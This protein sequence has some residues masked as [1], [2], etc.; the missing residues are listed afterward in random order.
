[1]SKVGPDCSF[2]N[3]SHRQHYSHF[4]CGSYTLRRSWM[5]QYSHEL[6]AKRTSTS[7]HTTRAD[8]QAGPFAYSSQSPHWYILAMSYPIA[9]GSSYRSHW[10]ALVILSSRY[11]R[12]HQHPANT[13]QLKQ[14]ATTAANGHTTTSASEAPTC[15]NSSF[16]SAPLRCS[17]HQYT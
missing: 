14:E 9:H 1:M 11:Q 2:V 10:A 12:Q 17:Q 5:P 13:I 15:C 6:A 3:H 8:R 4:V 16:S 7:T